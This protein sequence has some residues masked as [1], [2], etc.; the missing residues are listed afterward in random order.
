MNIQTNP[1]LIRAKRLLKHYFRT[2]F[3][4]A[5]ARW[6]GDNDIEVE[7][8]VDELISSLIGYI[9]EF[10]QANYPTVKKII[11]GG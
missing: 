7:D 8:I 6:D 1:H 2:A 10:H 5:G 11:E 3:E 9:N 4:K